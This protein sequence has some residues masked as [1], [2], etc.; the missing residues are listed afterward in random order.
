MGLFSRR[1][2][3]AKV[4]EKRSLLPGGLFAPTSL[5]LMFNN[6]AGVV[7]TTNSALQN[8]A[9]WACQRVLVSTISMLPVDVI[10]TQGKVR[11][12]VEPLPLVVRN[13]SGR[14]PRRGWVAQN[15]RALVG[16]GNIYG[17]IVATDSIGRATQVETIHPDKVNW[18]SESGVETPYIDGQMQTLWPIGDFW[19][20][21]ASQFLMPGSRVAMDP[22][23]F[24]KTSIGTGI[25][26]ERFGASFFSDG[27]NPSAIVRVDAD[28]NATEAMDIKRSIMNMASGD[29]SPAVFGNDIKD[30]LPWTAK[31]TDSQFIELLQF[32]VSQACRVYGVPPSMVYAA[33]SGQNVTYANASQ[34]DLAYLKYSITGWLV[35]LEDA[36]SELIEIP[37][38]VKFNIDA[39]LRM[40]AQG[41][42]DLAKTRLDSRTTSVNAVRALEDEA[43]FPD[44]IYDLPGVPGG[45][46]PLG[47]T[48]KELTPG[49]GVL[50]TADEART[51]LNANGAALEVPAP[52]TGDPAADARN[53][54]E[55]VQKIYLGV[56]VVVTDEEARAIL[57]NAGADLKGAMPTKPAQPSLPG[58]GGPSA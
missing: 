7:V 23:Q 28:I 49:V 31:L 53:I 44:P 55:M 4:E 50:I 14:V 43:P 11:T 51:I 45:S 32:E 40:D 34:A 39:L 22:T 52:T 33:I 15:I 26:A 3:A 29:R 54:A 47:Q 17:R 30:I 58:I 42:A 18:I 25:A 19:H 36:W 48:V 24:A 10:R 13:P 27:L 6:S 41:R 57:T 21:P 1:T 8:V 9:V 35:D 5:D 20:V 38:S 37:H 56:D 16:S 12:L 46:Q 2:K